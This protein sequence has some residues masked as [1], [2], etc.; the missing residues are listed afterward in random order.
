MKHVAELLEKVGGANAA[1]KCNLHRFE[2]CIVTRKASQ[3]ESLH[4][5]TV[6]GIF[7]I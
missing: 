7:S 3:K 4:S 2:L 1:I 6:V 5:K